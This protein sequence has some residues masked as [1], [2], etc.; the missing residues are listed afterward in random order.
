MVTDWAPVTGR[1]F[2]QVE[3][4]AENATLGPSNENS[5]SRV[6]KAWE[7]TT[8]CCIGAIPPGNLHKTDVCDSQME[9]ATAVPPNL[10]VVLR[11]A[12]VREVAR[13]VTLVLPVQAELAATVRSTDGKLWEYARETVE[14]SVEATVRAILPSLTNRRAEAALEDTEVTDLQLVEWLPVTMDTLSDMPPA[15]EASELV[16]SVTIAAPVVATLDTIGVRWATKS[17]EKA[18]FSEVLVVLMTVSTA[19]RVRS[20]ACD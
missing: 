4:T 3:E 8:T 20:A 9:A 7:V 18:R 6:A 14:G 10:R 16:E 19:G 15:L 11:S 2:I 13:T 1:L 5:A 12:A 17:T